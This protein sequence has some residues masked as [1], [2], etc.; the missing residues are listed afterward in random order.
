MIAII[1]LEI[2][3]VKSV[4][5]M[6][7][8]VGQ[9]SEIIKTP[10]KLNNIK[11]I[12]L[13]GVGAFDA[14]MSKLEESGFLEILNKLVLKDEIPILGICLGMQLLANYSEEGMK[15]GLGWIKGKV[16][17]FDVSKFHNSLKVPHMGW[18]LI[19]VEKE[20]P[21]FVK[22]PKTMRFYFVHSYH[23]QCDNHNDVSASAKYGYKFCAG[24]QKHNIMGVQFHPEKSHKFGKQV[25]KNFAEN[26]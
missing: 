14:A 4:A 24:V 17:K 8:K 25:L 15:P 10:D 1:D 18:N 22:V 6:L 7:R 23:F 11:K 19:K 3:N 16:V 9:D 12:I 26:C 5:N 21:L 13:P 20:Q 2:G